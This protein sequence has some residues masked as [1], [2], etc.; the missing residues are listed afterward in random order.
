MGGSLIVEIPTKRRILSVRSSLNEDSPTSVD[1]SCMR[2]ISRCR[3]DLGFTL[4]IVKGMSALS[5]KV[6]KDGKLEKAPRGE[7]VE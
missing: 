7:C 2:N 6:S 1:G 3:S 5:T 4:N